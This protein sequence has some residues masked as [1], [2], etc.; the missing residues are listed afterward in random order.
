VSLAILPREAEA[1]IFGSIFGVPAYAT[2]SL[3]MTQS[4]NNS[5]TGL[6]LIAQTSLNSLNKGSQK[7]AA[8]PTFSNSIVNID[9]T[10]TSLVSATGPAGVSDINDIEGGSDSD[11][12]TFYTVRDKDTWS[13]IAGMY[14]VTVD[15]I[16]SENDRKQGDRLITGELLLIPPVS[17]LEYTVK[18]GDSCATIAKTYKVPAGDIAD[19]ND[20]D[21]KCTINAG[22]KLFIPN[23]EKTIETAKPVQKAAK[24]SV[25]VSQPYLTSQPTKNISGYYANPVPGCIRTQG[26]HDGNAVDLGCPTG[27]PIHASASGTVVFAKMGNNGGYGNLVIIQHDNGTKTLYAHLSKIAVSVGEHVSQGQIIGYVGSTG[28]STGPH[29]HFAVQGAKNPGADGSWAK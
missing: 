22:D 4:G 17:G 6:A 20:L 23:A 9:P 12:V 29:L 13:G 16:L 15:T 7:T 8:D 5:Q 14:G 19:Y 10:G 27:T 1:S 26:L 18:S 21:A 24:S 25:K 11:Q 3:H 28:H 2:T